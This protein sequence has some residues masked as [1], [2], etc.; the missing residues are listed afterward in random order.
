MDL[1]VIESSTGK[2]MDQPI[3]RVAPEMPGVYVTRPEPLRMGRNR[4]QHVATRLDPFRPRFDRPE[5]V[6]DVFEDLERAHN[7]KGHI[8]MLG[9]HVVMN[10]APSNTGETSLPD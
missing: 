6:I 1:N 5:I 9:K 8:R 4:Q 10:D 7:V 3:S 2:H